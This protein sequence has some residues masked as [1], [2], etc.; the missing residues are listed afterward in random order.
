MYGRSALISK[1]TG[2]LA[3][4]LLS[5]VSKADFYQYVFEGIVPV[6][7]SNHSMVAD[8]ETWTATFIIDSTAEDTNPNPQFGVYE[9]AVVSGTLE[10]SGGYA[11][12]VDFSGATAFAL[13]DVFAPADADVVSVRGEYNDSN[14]VFQANTTELSTLTSDALVGPGLSF[15]SFPSPSE[16]EYFVF[17]YADEFGD[18]VYFGDTANNASF[19]STA[20]IPEPTNVVI[21]GWTVLGLLR[22]RR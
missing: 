5:T 7:V 11:P 18:I 19:V 2:I 15:D 3:I 9:G 8:G 22:R 1:I 16:L 14:F 20:V 4:L 21:L 10:F 12:F 17:T 6:G 13:D